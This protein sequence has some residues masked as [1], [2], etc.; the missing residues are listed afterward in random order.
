MENLVSFLTSAHACVRLISLENI[1]CISHFYLMHSCNWQVVPHFC[2]PS[3]RGQQDLKT[4]ELV[5]A[6][7]LSVTCRDIEQVGKSQSKLDNMILSKSVCASHEAMNLPLLMV[8]AH[9]SPTQETPKCKLFLCLLVRQVLAHR[10][11]LSL[12]MDES[13]PFIAC[14][15]LKGVRRTWH[16]MQFSSYIQ[17]HWPPFISLLFNKMYNALISL[18]AIYFFCTICIYYCYSDNCRHTRQI[19]EGDC[20]PINTEIFSGVKF[21]RNWP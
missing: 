20:H 10:V 12:L 1:L 15:S 8:H 9:F 11:S 7:Q 5:G 18:Y 21:C 14:M 19:E 3:E 6:P 13:E 2:L 17:K 4:S 16:T